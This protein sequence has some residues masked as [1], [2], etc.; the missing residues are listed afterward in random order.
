VGV[1]DDEQVL[2][3]ATEA[4]FFTANRNYK[5]ACAHSTTRSG[6][7]AATSRNGFSDSAG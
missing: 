2:A 6:N 3:E 5:K 7:C 4:F 1:V